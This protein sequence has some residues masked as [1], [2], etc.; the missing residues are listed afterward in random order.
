MLEPL[1]PVEAKQ[2]IRSIL[3]SGD[4]SV[5]GHAREEMEAEDLS[6][7][8]CVNVLRGGV[9]HPAEWEHGSW[10]HRV[11]TSRITVVIAFRSEDYFVVVTAWRAAP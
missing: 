7:A 5:T 2:R 11:E 9:V 10:R 1:S 8:D 6:I 4:F 3:A